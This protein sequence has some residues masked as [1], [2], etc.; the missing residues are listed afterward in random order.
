MGLRQIK[1][2]GI[3]HHVQW[4]L[5]NTNCNNKITLFL[6]SF[7]LVLPP[8][9]QLQLIVNWLDGPYLPLCVCYVGLGVLKSLNKFHTFY[10]R[11]FTRAK[12]VMRYV[13]CFSQRTSCSQK[14]YS[15][16]PIEVYCSNIAIVYHDFL[17]YQ[18]NLKKILKN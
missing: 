5:L 15:F 13:F 17:R 6:Y 9:Y 3:W 14:F 11:T 16:I 12:I 7:I 10:L 18:C 2:H 1:N 8:S 4:L